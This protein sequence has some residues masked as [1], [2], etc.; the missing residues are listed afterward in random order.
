MPLTTDPAAPTPAAAHSPAAEER[1]RRPRALM[2]RVALVGTTLIFLA[3][4]SLLV[5]R[6]ATV[7]VPDS[8]L[9]VRGSPAWEGALVSVD[10]FTFAS[11]LTATVDRRARHTISY[12]LSPGTYTLQVRRDGAMLFSQELT[13]TRRDHITVLPLP[14]APP[15]EPPAATQP[16]WPFGT[17]TFPGNR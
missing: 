8:M 11:P 3:C 7:E 13:M 5:Y 17:P 15:A 4:A 2:V 12:H 10:N 9:I 6:G 1:P 14:D 16:Y